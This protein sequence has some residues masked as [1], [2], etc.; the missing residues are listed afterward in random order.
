MIVLRYME[1][2]TCNH[3]E[4]TMTIDNFDEGLKT[5]KMCLADKKSYH[6]HN[7]NTMRLKK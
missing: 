7:I 6:K 4:R 3:C 1:D 2:K 5:C